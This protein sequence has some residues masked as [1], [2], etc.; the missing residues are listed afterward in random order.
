M[1]T[2]VITSK[3]NSGGTIT[4]LGLT[5]VT[6]GNDQA[7]TITPSTGYITLAIYVDNVSVTVATTYTFTA[8]AAAHT[9]VAVFVPTGGYYCTQDD[10]VSMVGTQ[11]LADL[12]NDT[13]NQTVPDPTV[14][15]AMIAIAYEYT[16]AELFDIYTTPF[17]T[18]PGIIRDINV[19]IAVYNCFLRKF[20]IM[21]MPREWSEIYKE[22]KE[23]LDKISSLDLVLDLTIASEA[24]G[25]NTE[26]AAPKIDFQ[27]ED[28]M[29]SLF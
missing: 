7:Y 23:M 14:T 9:I 22:A 27:D 3:R 8:V 17:T 29:E 15:T 21:Q 19:K 1:A 11:T 10:L 20:S 2:I 24:G 16:N 4:P 28:N 13:A 6:T 12:T 26:S 18:V 25:I 5:T